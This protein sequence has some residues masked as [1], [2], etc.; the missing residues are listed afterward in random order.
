MANF[1]IYSTESGEILSTGLCPPSLIAKQELKPGTAITEGIAT[2][3]TQ[4]IDIDTGKILTKSDLN[5][6]IWNYNKI[7][8]KKPDLSDINDIDDPTL[9][10]RIEAF[11][12]NQISAPAWR[13]ENYTVL[14]RAA[15]S[16]LSDRADAATKIA[17]GDEV[18]S[19]E[20]VEQLNNINAHDIAVK[21]RFPKE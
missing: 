11:F 14:R 16:S 21:T 5:Q 12:Y 17:S 20:G 10:A 3:A 2:P 7:K 15:Y 4:Y 9:N 8:N 13:V 18:L 6:A 19:A 1:I